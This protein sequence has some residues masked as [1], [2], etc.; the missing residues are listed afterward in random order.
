MATHE[1]I[2]KFNQSGFCKYQNHCRKQHIND[3]GPTSMCNNMAC[4]LRHPKV[5]K[6]FTNFRRC[7]FGESCAYLH[8][9][10][11]QTEDKNISELEHELENVKAKISEIDA[12]LLKLE[13][14]ESRISSMEES[15]LRNREEIDELKKN[16]NQKT[17]DIEEVKKI[18]DQK[19]SKHDELAQNFYILM[20][21]VDD[22]EKSSA[23]LKHHLNH[24]SKQIQTFQCNLCGQAFQNEQTLRNHFQR[25]HG[26]SKT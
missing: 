11:T 15:N 1:S 19:S 18:L 21:S 4:L 25:N 3:S 17:F 24:L 26:A 6:Y 14:I 7:K 5:C 23:Q 8:G 22:L 9:H 10:D 13:Q 16:L 2:C 20:H 12:I